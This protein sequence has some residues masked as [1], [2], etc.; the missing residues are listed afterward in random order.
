MQDGSSFIQRFTSLLVRQEQKLRSGDFPIAPKNSGF[1]SVAE[2]L[3]SE[4]YREHFS[5]IDKKRGCE[6]E[7][8]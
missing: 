1:K 8:R 3:G 7:K 4:T 6:Y 2:I 5:K